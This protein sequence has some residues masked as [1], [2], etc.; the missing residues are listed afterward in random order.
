MKIKAGD[1][2]FHI[3]WSDQVES[4]R[5][6]SYESPEQRKKYNN[7]SLDNPWSKLV[8]NHEKYKNLAKPNDECLQECIEVVE[9]T[10]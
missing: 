10:I 1:Q 9:N 4:S 5:I 6:R 2:Y 8:E 7:I 3:V